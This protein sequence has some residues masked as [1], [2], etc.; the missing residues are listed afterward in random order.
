M[1]ILVSTLYALAHTEKLAKKN[2][3]DTLNTFDFTSIKLKSNNQ[4]INL[5][6][7]KCGSSLCAL[8]DKDKNVTLEDSKNIIFTVKSKK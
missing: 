5:Y 3:Q 8:I 6:L 4:P 7:I 1:V 2:A